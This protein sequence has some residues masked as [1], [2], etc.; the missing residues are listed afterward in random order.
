ML[1]EGKLVESTANNVTSPIILTLSCVCRVKLAYLE[2]PVNRWGPRSIYVQ[3]SEFDYLY[4]VEQGMISVSG[5]QGLPGKDGLP[6]AKG[7]KGGT[8]IVGMRGIKVCTLLCGVTRQMLVCL[9]W[10]QP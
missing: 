9:V 1:N 7:D 6:G 4:C 8:G 3:I 2:Y 5:L 10:Y